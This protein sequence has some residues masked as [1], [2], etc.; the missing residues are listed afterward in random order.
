VLLIG[1]AP[2]V[3]VNS[4]ITPTAGTILGTGGVSKQGLSIV[5]SS[6]ALV[7]LGTAAV[8]PPFTPDTTGNKTWF[9]DN[10][11]SK[12]WVLSGQEGK[13]ILK[14]QDNRWFL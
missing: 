14:K 3:V 1:T 9:L 2:S 5:P 13:W 10:N 6:G 12:A 4:Y 8:P 11:Y 7:I